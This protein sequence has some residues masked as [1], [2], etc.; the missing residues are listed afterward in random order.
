[1]SSTTWKKTSA[2][3]EMFSISFAKSS[4]RLRTLA[5][6]ARRD[7]GDAAQR[8]I[9]RGVRSVGEVEELVPLTTFEPDQP[10]YLEEYD[11]TDRG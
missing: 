2:R 10:Y 9:G 8:V 11:L 3:V 4:T 7:L 6:G 5:D 1:M